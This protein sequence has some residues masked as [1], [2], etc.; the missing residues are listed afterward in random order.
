M[1]R[2]AIA[3]CAEFPA[4]DE[5]GALLAQIAQAHGIALSFHDWR[6]EEDIWSDVDLTVVRT[7]WDYTDHREEFLEWTQRVPRLLNQS[8]VL[9]WNTDKRYLDDLR[10][11]GIPT[12][13]TTYLSSLD[14][15]H[16]F[17]WNGE[18]AFV[19]KPTVGA[20][21]LGAR[22]FDAT[23]IAIAREHAKA[24]IA[25]GK[26]VMVQPYQDLVDQEHETAV[27]LINGWPSHAI[28][29]GPLLLVTELDRSRL[30]RQEQISAR[31]ADD[32]QH[33]VAL[34]AH[35]AVVAHLGLSEALL[36]ARVDLVP[37]DHG[38]VVIEFEA[39]EPSL[40]LTYDPSAAETFIEA[41]KR[42]LITV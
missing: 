7:T 22:K 28:A 24:L 1:P 34:A 6:T 8:E 39:T 4:G 11:L 5:D 26:E 38:P 32:E 29:K 9:A 10:A 35:A 25:A 17:E 41:L 37:S 16:T 40:F 12:I 27:M 20:G 19:L 21:S 15:S 3:T 18:G 2:V 30:F 33:L 14:E 31:V 13:A 42:R 36:Y 23:E